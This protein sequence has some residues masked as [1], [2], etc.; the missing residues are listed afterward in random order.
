MQS[1]RELDGDKFPANE[2]DLH[3]K[4][5]LKKLQEEVKKE[6][7]GFEKRQ[8][9]DFYLFNNSFLPKRELYEQKKEAEKITSDRQKFSMIM[10]A[11]S[12]QSGVSIDRMK[13]HRRFRETWIPRGVA[14]FLTRYCTDLS[15]NEI[16]RAVVHGVKLDHSTISHTCR[17]IKD[18]IDTREKITYSLILNVVSQLNDEGLY[19]N[20]KFHQPVWYQRLVNKQEKSEGQTLITG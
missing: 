10:R 4:I 18:A 14:I 2:F 1:A 16:G 20:F 5:E 15:M 12:E 13:M 7:Y 6:L 8:V 11:V 17:R 19:I 3:D 9:E